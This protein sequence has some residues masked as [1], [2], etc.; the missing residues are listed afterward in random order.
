MFS[1]NFA[2]PMSDSPNFR[3]QTQHHASIKQRVFSKIVKMSHFVHLCIVIFNKKT[4]ENAKYPC[5]LLIFVNFTKFSFAEQKTKN[6]QNF[7]WFWN[8]WKLW[9]REP[10]YTTPFKKVTCNSFGKSSKMHKHRKFWRIF[11]LCAAKL[12]FVKTVKN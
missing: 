7:Q 1:A 5:K 2:N 8:F 9:C 4:Y 11:I 12:I 3:S 6:P 10:L